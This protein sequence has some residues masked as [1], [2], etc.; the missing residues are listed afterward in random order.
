MTGDNQ[1][2]GPPLSSTCSHRFP[3]LTS[4]HDALCSYLSVSNCLIPGDL[5]AKPVLSSGNATCTDEIHLR[6]RQHT[7]REELVVLEYEHRLQRPRIN[8]QFLQ[9]LIVR[10]R[11]FHTCSDGDILKGPFKTVIQKFQIPIAECVIHNLTRSVCSC[12]PNSGFEFSFKN[13]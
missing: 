12:I 2:V 8:Y 3:M 10:E 7:S 5:I 11:T 1:L 9:A 6:L 13:R 4:H